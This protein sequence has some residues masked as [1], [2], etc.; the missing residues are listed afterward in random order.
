MS[1]VLRS[2]LNVVC[3]E[4]LNCI[5]LD[6]IC[7]HPRLSMLT[8]SAQLINSKISNPR[9]RTYQVLIENMAL[10]NNSRLDEHQT[11]PRTSI[12]VHEIY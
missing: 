2:H 9:I 10:C 6:Q 4:N 8:Y 7:F 5:L 12:Y 1:S 3:L 11:Q